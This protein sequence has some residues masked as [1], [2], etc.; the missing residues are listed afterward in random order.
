MF[1][2][3]SISTIVICFFW[4]PLLY[5]QSSE[6]TSFTDSL[7][8]ALHTVKEDT[9]KVTIL[10]SLAYEYKN[11]NPDSGLYYG[12]QAIALAQKLQWKTGLGS[13]LNN[14]GK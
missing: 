3:I 12:Q 8:H 5:A 13:A 4:S 1:K 2:C 6:E 7:Q 11:N 9:N 10:N 14:R